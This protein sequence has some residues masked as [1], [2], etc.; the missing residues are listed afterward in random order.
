[1]PLAANLSGSISLKLISIPEI[2]ITKN[3]REK[4][5]PTKIAT[6]KSK[7]TV[8]NIVIQNCAI[9]VFSFLLNIK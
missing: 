3:T 9:A 5:I 2:L 6:V 4:R 7:A 8:A 1:M